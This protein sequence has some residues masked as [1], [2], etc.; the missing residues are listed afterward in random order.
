MKK[1][2]TVK[3][4]EDFY[5]YLK[6]GAKELDMTLNDFMQ[7]NFHREKLCKICGLRKSLHFLVDR[8]HRFKE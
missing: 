2:R 3:V 6:E 5:K 4:D 7:V 1:Y 8:N